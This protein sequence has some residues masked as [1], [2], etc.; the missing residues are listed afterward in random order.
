MESA[1]IAAI[2]NMTEQI[3]LLSQDFQEFRQKGFEPINI[4]FENSPLT[5]EQ[6]RTIDD[7]R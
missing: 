7:Q 5:K 1:L 3:R 2:E 4:G 6:E